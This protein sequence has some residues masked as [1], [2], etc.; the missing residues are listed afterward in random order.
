MGVSYF[1]ARG[2]VKSVQQITGA[3][4]SGYGANTTVQKDESINTVDPDK[5]VVILNTSWTNYYNVYAELR[6][7]LLNSTTVRLE[8][9]NSGSGSSGG[10]V[11]YSA[12]VVEYY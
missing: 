8:I 9:H 1:P 7:W 4:E 6:A 11:N 3:F 2:A 10:A 5:T 12:V